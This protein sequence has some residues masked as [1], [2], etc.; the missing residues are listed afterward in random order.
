MSAATSVRKMTIDELKNYRKLTFTIRY[1]KN[2]LSEMRR[3]SLVRS[4]EITGMPMGSNTPD[5]TA[6]RAIAEAKIMSRIERLVAEQEAE[7]ERVLAWIQSIDDPMIQVI[8][9]SRYIRGKSWA[10][11]S[12]AVGG[13][14]S[15]DSV[16]MIHNR[17]LFGL[18]RENLITSTMDEVH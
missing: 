8:M 7:T 16:R 13:N 1:W 4:P 12:M 17:Y 2:E 18:F 15:P 14:N 3:K 10:A 6:E 9:H 5:P 11:V